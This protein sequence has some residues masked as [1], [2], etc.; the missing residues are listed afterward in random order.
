M[1]SRCMISL[2]CV[3]TVFTVRWSRWA[4]SLLERPSATS[5]RTSP[6]RGGADRWAG[7][8]RA[9]VPRHVVD[10]EPV[11]DLAAVRLHGLHGEVEPLGDLLAGEALGHELQDLP[12]ARGEEVEHARLAHPSQVLVHD[13]LRDRGRQVRFAPRHRLEGELELGDVGPLEEI[14][15]GAGP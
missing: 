12:L 11:H 14:A 4:I 9:T 15:P 3:S 10:V 8:P 6:W 2:R 13:V 5:L 7:N 1:S